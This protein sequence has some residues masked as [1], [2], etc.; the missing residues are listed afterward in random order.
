MDQ[1]ESL[2]KTKKKLGGKPL[3]QYAIETGLNC[4]SIDRVIVSTD[5]EEIAAI[6]QKAGADVPFLRPAHLATDTAPTIGV[7][8]HV[9]DFLDQ[10]GDIYEGICLLQ[11]TVPF[12]DS[13]D[14]DNALQQ[15]STSQA[16]SLVTVREVPHQ[17]NPYWV[18]EQNTETGYLNLA[19]PATQPVKRRQDLP[20]SLSSG[21]VLIPYPLETNPGTTYL[22]WGENSPLYHEKLPR[23]QS[24]HA[25]RLVKGR[26]IPDTC[27]RTQ[28]QE[29]TFVTLFPTALLPGCCSR[30]D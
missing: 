9:L 26:T 10:A 19:L 12:R 1:R 7:L 14:M 4:H 13:W 16:D 8:I 29:L 25:C 5:D 3:V 22:V 18:Y 15:F 17:Y 28:K 20:K 11:P 2:E 24:R 30:R 27:Q 21:W 23:H 6:S